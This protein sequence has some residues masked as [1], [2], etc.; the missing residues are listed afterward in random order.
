MAVI[1]DFVELLAEVAEEIAEGLEFEPGQ[2]T[3]VLDELFPE[4]R[5]LCEHQA[6]IELLLRYCKTW[7]RRP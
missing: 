3:E 6:T 2:D 4:L 1:D 5:A 7:G